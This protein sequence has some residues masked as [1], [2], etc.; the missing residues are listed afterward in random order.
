MTTPTI[1]LLVF[2][3]GL[4]AFLLTYLRAVRGAAKLAAADQV[5]LDFLIQHNVGVVRPDP[6]F[7]VLVRDLQMTGSGHD[8]RAVIDAEMETING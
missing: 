2:L 5:R 6:E 7:W 4:L 1:V 3:V 8:L